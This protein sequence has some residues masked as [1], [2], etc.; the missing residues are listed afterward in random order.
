MTN[1][2]FCRAPRTWRTRRA[3]VAGPSP[4]QRCPRL[5]AGARTSGVRRSR[6]AS[7]PS[8]VP[9]R[10]SFRPEQLTHQG[11]AAAGSESS[12]AGSRGSSDSSSLPLFARERGPR[13][14]GEACAR[15]RNCVHAAWKASRQRRSSSIR[16]ASVKVSAMWR[17][18]PVLNYFVQA[19]RLHATCDTAGHFFRAVMMRRQQREACCRPP[20]SAPARYGRMPSSTHA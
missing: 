11:A 7:M 18:V 9:C 16:S 2:C 1:C 15:N 14:R 6:W 10:G 5:A 4:A 13:Y 17:S 20:I 19:T 8:P 3:L 12:H